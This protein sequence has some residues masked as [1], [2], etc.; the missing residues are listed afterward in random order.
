MKRLRRLTHHLLA[1]LLLTPAL[2]AQ[3]PDTLLHAIPPPPVGV[4]TGGHLGYSVAVEG[5]YTVTGVPFDDTGGQDSGMVK[6]F[7]SG[8]GALLF[9]LPNPSPA[10]GDWFGISVGI[11]GTRVV[12][13]ARYD[14]TGATDAGNAYVYEI[15]SATPTVPVVT[16]NNPSPAADDRFGHS[17]AISGTRVVVGAPN[18]DSGATDAGRGYVYELTSGTPNVP[19]LTLNNPS[20]ALGDHFGSSVAIDGTRV[21]VGAW[22]YDTG[23]SNAGSAYVYDLASPTPTVPNATLNN[24]RPAKFDQFGHSVAISGTQVVVGA[25]WDVTGATHPGSAFVYDLTSATP[26]IPSVTLNNPSPAANGW[27]GGSVAISGTR[28]VVGA[29]FDAT[30]ATDTGSAYIY[31]LTSATPTVPTATLN[32]P[33]PAWRD[34]FGNSVSIFGTRVVVG[35][36]YDD[37]GAKD[38]GSAYVYNLTSA[39]PTVPSATLNSPGSAALRPSP[40]ASSSSARP[41]TTP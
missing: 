39:T 9:V 30:G 4:Q 13:G 16:L 23:A 31:D 18:D 33:S 38:A 36:P 14:D 8:T 2:Q 19:L 17:V 7:H 32:N 6:V 15:T 40:A 10:V 5:D 12:V 22:S 3:V 26:T 28:V 20:P 29:K 35:A 1:T 21:V 27:F 24:P 41:T 25:P 37:T 11:S 34:N